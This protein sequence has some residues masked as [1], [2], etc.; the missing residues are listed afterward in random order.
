MENLKLEVKNRY[1][2]MRQIDIEL[3]Y[4][5]YKKTVDALQRKE[6]VAILMILKDHI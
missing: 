4:Q 3:K 1:K 5:N 2:Q 6:Q